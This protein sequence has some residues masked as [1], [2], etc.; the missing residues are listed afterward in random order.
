MTIMQ[1]LRATQSFPGRQMDHRCHP[2]S[3]K[4]TQLSERLQSRCN[5]GTPLLF[6]TVTVSNTTA[7]L[8]QKGALNWPPVIPRDASLSDSKYKFFQSGVSLACGRVSRTENFFRFLSNHTEFRLFL[9]FF[10]L[11]W[12]RT[13]FRLVLNQS[14]LSKYKSNFGLLYENET[15]NSVYGDIWHRYHHTM[16]AIR[17]H[18]HQLWIRIACDFFSSS[19]NG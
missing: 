9:A 10:R 16:D 4:T 5:R 1:S 14:E 13:E 12:H 15:K 3:G 8:Y 19:E 11:I 6:T 18:H 17:H 2:A 7:L